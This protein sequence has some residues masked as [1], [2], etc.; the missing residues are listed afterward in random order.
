[1]RPG[2]AR[3]GEMRRNTARCGVMRRPNVVIQRSTTILPAS[4]LDAD[5]GLWALGAV[6]SSR[7]RFCFGSLVSRF[8][9]CL[10]LLRRFFFGFRCCPQRTKSEINRGC[11]A[12]GCARTNAREASARGACNDVSVLFFYFPLIDRS[13]RFIHIMKVD[14]YWI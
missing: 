8:A 6:K 12:S 1:M 5:A 9:S 11:R 2:A 4:V 10:L 3:G 7:R 13:K 14:G